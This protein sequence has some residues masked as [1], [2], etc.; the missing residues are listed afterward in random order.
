[1]RSVELGFALTMVL[2]ASACEPGPNASPKQPQGD[3][4]RLESRSPNPTTVLA[5]SFAYVDSSGTRLLALSSLAQP[6]GIRAAVC[7]G[8]RSFQ[9][10]FE[11]T[12]VRQDVD[13][14]RQTAANF[15]NQDGQVFRVLQGQARPDETCFL[16]PDSLLVATAR[17]I[18]SL[19]SPTCSATD[20]S[21]LATAKK[22]QVAHCSLF[23]QTPTGAQ[24]FAV[25]FV[26]IGSDALGSL[27]VD[28]GGSMLFQDFPG[29]YRG[30][31]EGVWRVEDQGRF[32]LEGAD[33]LFVAEFSTRYVMA[34]AWAGSEGESDHLLV[35]DS[36]GAFRTALSAYRYW[37]P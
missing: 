23:A 35:A 18:T 22:R 15:A 12:Q 34:L 11:R 33:V 19:S 7:A 8:S 30:P 17:A 16:S 10:Q 26:R 9:V 27:V 36:S 14:G 2:T 21:R 32:S 28:R 37:V 29:I 25:Q 1:M 13:N 24:L 3:A 5:G 4:P 31:D 6:A 20:S